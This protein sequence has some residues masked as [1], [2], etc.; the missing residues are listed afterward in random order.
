MLRTDVRLGRTDLRL[1]RT[2]VRHGRSGGSE[3]RAQGGS[4]EGRTEVAF[5]RQAG[6]EGP[7][8]SE[9]VLEEVNAS[10]SISRLHL[11]ATGSTVIPAVGPVVFF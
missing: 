11:P 2:V 9:K 4:E 10:R 1:R 8:R 6:P 5:R 7:G 3:G